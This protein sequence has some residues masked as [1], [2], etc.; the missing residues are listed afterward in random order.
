MIFKFKGWLF[1]CLIQ[2]KESTEIEIDVINLQTS[3]AF[4]I[5]TSLLPMFPP[6]CTKPVPYQSRLIKEIS[7]SIWRQNHSLSY[8]ISKIYYTFI[9][10]TLLFKLSFKCYETNDDLIIEIE[11]THVWY[12]HIIIHSN[13]QPVSVF[14]YLCIFFGFCI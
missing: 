7:A 14:C 13:V 10:N 5:M 1:V 6:F 2:A 8:M 12:Y 4:V 9:R 11:I 3:Q